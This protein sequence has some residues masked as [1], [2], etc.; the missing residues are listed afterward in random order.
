MSE[1][2]SPLS[3]QEVQQW[4]TIIAA[5]NLYNLLHHCRVCHREWIASQEEFC[6]C[7]NTQVERIACWQFPDD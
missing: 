7:G 4:Q 5:A 2:L 6:L 1:P 3:A